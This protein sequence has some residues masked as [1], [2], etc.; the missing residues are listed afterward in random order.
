MT[1]KSFNFYVA[2]KHV[3]LEMMMMMMIIIIITFIGYMCTIQ[4]IGSNA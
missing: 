1:R 4:W 2:N 3:C